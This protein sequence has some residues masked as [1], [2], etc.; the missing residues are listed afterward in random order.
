MEAHRFCE[1]FP[2]AD[3]STLQD[4]A[5]SISQHGLQEDI[6]TYEGKI[7]DGRSRYSACL[8]A[9][10]EPVF[11]EYDGDDALQ[12]VITKNLHRRHLLPWRE[13]FQDFLYKACFRA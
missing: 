11:E 8:M 3:E 4:M 5:N 1:I 13:K 2:V 10:V 9:G 12:Y 7:L 6:V